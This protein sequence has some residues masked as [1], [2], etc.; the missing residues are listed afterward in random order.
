MSNVLNRKKSIDKKVS[1][2]EE[3]K[4]EE[5]IDILSEKYNR[6]R[7]MLSEENK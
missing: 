2:L 6:I 4:V 5:Y 3:E 7:K 1:K